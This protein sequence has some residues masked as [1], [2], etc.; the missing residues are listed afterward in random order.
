[1]SLAKVEAARRYR[2]ALVI[3]L[4]A[5]AGIL[6]GN[7]SQCVNCPIA[8]IGAAEP[9]PPAADP[10]AELNDAFRTAYRQARADLLAK[11]SPLVVVEGDKLV[12]LRNGKRTEVEVNPQAHH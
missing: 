5:F 1:M 10:L 4:G 6:S 12:L 11:V 7:H 8:I 3:W 2:R 9:K